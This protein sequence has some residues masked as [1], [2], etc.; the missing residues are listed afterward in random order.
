MKVL[1]VGCGSIGHRHIRNLRALGVS[2]ILAFDPAQERLE[3]V[4][5][6]HQVFA[7][8]TLE[9]GLAQNPDA[10]LVCTPPHLHTLV[11]QQAL[12]A[13]AHVFIEKPIANTLD[14]L[15]DLL[16]KARLHKRLICVGYNLRFQA[17]LCKLKEMLDGGAIGKPLMICAEFGQYLPDWRPSQDYR[18]GYNVS[19]EMGGGIILDASHELDYVRWLGGEVESVYC[20]AGHLSSLEMDTEDAAAITLRLASGIIV[21]VHLDCI[22][23]S[24]ARN[25]KVAGEEGTL[26]WDFNEGVRLYLAATGRWETFPM[27]EKPND[28]YVEEMRHFLA[29]LCGEA[30]P[31][32]DGYTG[33]RVLEIALAARQSA[34]E[35]RAVA[36]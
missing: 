33:R 29:C 10:V 12:E 32:V 34:A 23:R 21:E 24:Y 20:V 30:T 3:G 22:Q 17:R 15:D 5:Q 26:M 35:G 19:A 8:P 28:M 16:A 36:L 9:S 13:G 18:T 4:A 14:G 27:T 6:E 1:V 11:A 31:V 25:C 2:D 7:C